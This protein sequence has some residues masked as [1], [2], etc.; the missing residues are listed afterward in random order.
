[1]KSLIKIITIF[2]GCEKNEPFS[3]VSQDRPSSATVVQSNIGPI[4]ILRV[5]ATKMENELSY[6]LAKNGAQ[7]SVFFME[8]FIKK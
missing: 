3:P 5:D 8:K 2:S 6:S 1:M 4:K 7:D